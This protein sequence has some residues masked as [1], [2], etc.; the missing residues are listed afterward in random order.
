MPYS[1]EYKD[2][3][4]SDV[5][6]DFSIREISGNLP[7]DGEKEITC[8]GI[9]FIGLLKDSDG[10]LKVKMKPVDGAPSEIVTYFDI[11]SKHKVTEP[12]DIIDDPRL[13]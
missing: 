9:G 6:A 5:T 1:Q 3:T 7:P 13:K 10:L 12:L 4:N 2:W 11:L 8:D